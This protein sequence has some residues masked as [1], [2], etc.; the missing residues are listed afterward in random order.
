MNKIFLFLIAA[1]LLISCNNN[2]TST[3]KTSDTTTLTDDIGRNVAL[4]KNPQRIISFAPNVTEMIFYLG[5]GEK[6][7]GVT[8]WCNYPP[9]AKEKEIIG[10][11]TTVNLE[12]ILA[13]KPDLA[14]MVGTKNTPLLSKLESITIPVLVLN[15]IRIDDIRRDILLLSSILG[16]ISEADPLL[17]DFDS[18]IKNIGT[19]VDSI[20]YDQ[21]PSV[22][23]EISSQPLM[24][25]GQNSLIGQL[26]EKAG[27]RNIMSD[28][29]QDYAVIS[30]EAVIRLKPEIII[31]LHPQTDKR[32][33]SERFGWQN[34][35][36][37]KNGRIYDNLDLDILLRPGPRIADG[38][39]QLNKIFNEK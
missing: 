28:L 27:G 31:I 30:Q 3:G 39:K 12:R 17:K 24:S 18:I 25:A 11:A 1:G 7:V 38:L 2:Q 22:Y 29:K 8:S 26:I 19:S 16:R 13:L 35:P 14:V 34:I 15:P 4:G 33:L 37:V 9:E 36:A 5:A 32:K 21:R 23:A 6:L 20:P 10:D